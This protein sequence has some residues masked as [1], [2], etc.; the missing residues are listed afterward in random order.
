[1]KNTPLKE[2][3]GLRVRY[4]SNDGGIQGWYWS[5]DGDA[6]EEGPC[7]SRIQAVALALNYLERLHIFARFTV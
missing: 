5:F 3:A 6:K 4:G 1:M 7:D 2:D